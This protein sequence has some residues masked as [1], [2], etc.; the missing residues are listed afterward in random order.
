M[1]ISIKQN[2][3][4]RQG[5]SLIVKKLVIILWGFLMGGLLNFINVPAGWLIG[6]MIAGMISAMTFGRMNS[7][8]Y[9][10][11][12]GLCLLGIK[13]RCKYKY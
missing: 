9:V 1:M 12:S 10:F 11:K 2:A 5:L 7:N 4:R 3:E 6:A 13:F 8:K